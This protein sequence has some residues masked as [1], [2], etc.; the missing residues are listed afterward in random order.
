QAGY[1]A[2]PEGGLHTIPDRHDDQDEPRAAHR[3]REVV[4]PGNSRLSRGFGRTVTGP[5]EG[6][7]YVRVEFALALV[8]AL[9]LGDGH[10]ATELSILELFEGLAEHNIEIGA[11][12]ADLRSGNGGE[13][14]QYC[15]GRFLF[16]PVREAVTGVV[17]MTFDQK[18]RREDALAVPADGD[19]NVRGSEHAD[20]RVGDGL[21]GA[22]IVLTL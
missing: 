3:P 12:L 1:P 4:A 9:H 14:A 21:D 22:E 19:V 15:V 13:V 18:L 7:L 17:G 5:P 8:A 2:T 6:G 10:A 11:Q 16:Y 20:K